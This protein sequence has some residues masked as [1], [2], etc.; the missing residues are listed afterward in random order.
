MKD[1]PLLQFT[2]KK[3]DKKQQA[4]TY[5]TAQDATMTTAANN[6]EDT[7]L[8]FDTITA[9]RTRD[10]NDKGERSVLAWSYDK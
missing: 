5:K 4:E 10:R 7:K 2:T 8:L 1:N 9:H 3:E 6:N